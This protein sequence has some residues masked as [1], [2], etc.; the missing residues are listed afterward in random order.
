MRYALIG[1]R[2]VIGLTGLFLLS[3]QK[4][5]DLPEE[6]ALAMNTIPQHVDYTYDVK[7]ILSDRCFACHGPDKNKQKAGLRLDRAE[8]AYASSSESGRRA[9]VP[10]STGTSELAHRI[11]SADPEQIMPTPDSHLS[12]SAEEKAI[13]IRWIEQGAEYKPHWAFTK[14][15][16]PQVPEVKNRQWVRNEIDQFILR[17]IESKGLRPAHEAEKTTLLRRVYLDLTG[18][19]PTPEQVDAFL[20][21][22]SPTAYEK[23]VDKLLASSE[24]GEHMA[25]FWMDASRYADTHGYQDDVKRTAWP[26]RDWVIRAFTTNLPYDQFVTHQLAGDLLPKPSRDQLIATA[27]NRMHPQNQEGGIIA[28][29]YRTEYVADRVNTFGKLFLGLTVECARC[30]DH[31]YDPISQKDY[32][33]LY[34]FFNNNNENGQVPYNGEA[35]PSLTLPTPDVESKLNQIRKTLAEEKPRLQPEVYKEAF[36]KWVATAESN[37]A[38]LTVQDTKGLVGYFKFDEPDGREFKNEADSKHKAYSQGEDSLSKLASRPGKFGRSRFIYGSNAVDFGKDF[39]YFERN[40]PFTIST[41]FKIHDA[42]LEGTLIHKSNSVITGYRGWNIFRLADGRL[43]IMISNVW[44]ENA[45]E[46]QTVE[47]FPLKKWAHIAF[48]YDGLSK[49]R[50]VRVYIDGAPSNVVVHNDN[51]TQSILYGKN[52][53]IP[54]EKTLMIGRLGDLFTKNFEIDELRIYS[55]ALT[56]LEMSALY[57]GQNEVARLLRIPGE[58]RTAGQEAALLNYYTAHFDANYQQVLGKSLKLIGEETDLLNGQV[59]LMIMKERKFARKT[60][61]LNRGAYDAPG[62][63]V[64]PDTPDQFFKIPAEYPKNRLGLAR[65]LLHEDHPIFARVTVNQFWQQ[66]FGKGLVNTSDDFGNQGNLPT[67]PELLDWLAIRLRE[68]K[69]D[70]KAFRKMIVLSATYRQSSVM[71]P[72]VVRLDPDNALYTRSPSY[73]LS[74]EQ[75]RDNALVSS[76]LLVKKVGGPSVYPYQPKGVWEALAASVYLPPYPQDTGS[77]LYRRSLYTIIKRTAPPPSLITFDASDRNVC[78][79]RRQKTSTPLQALITL[80]DPQYI[81]ASRL[82]AE[83]MIKKER[84]I[85]Q[86]VVYAFK[87]LTSR[88]PRPKEVEILSELYEKEYQDFKRSPVKVRA[89]LK[90]GDFPADKSLNPVEIAACTTVASTIMNFDE[91]LIKR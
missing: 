54:Y 33:S 75:I 78:V 14:V 52:K 9:I 41:W 66:I 5:I 36:R 42:K 40:Q 34:A 38:K 43:R 49:A 30:H 47:K 18:L 84:T 13:L 61:I 91:F 86:R 64:K 57:S 20:N 67:H 8:G 53:E 15:E 24:Y 59:D 79:V 62:K 51:L 27:F 3:C 88:P 39:G 1:L 22:Q 73:R 17:K 90:V 12:L 35:S 31:K 37:P 71:S 72:E 83:K 56:P 85:K 74:A 50:G 68:M 7:P 58:R 60:Y 19:S 32:F 82:L 44:P 46:I 11:L 2:G 89:L 65:W 69:W 87:A 16:K 77:G 80:N 23:V 21:D 48:S 29:E 26:F 63:E 81:E 25:S 70:V 28:E 45:I 4:N 10:G 76:G 55:R 6:V